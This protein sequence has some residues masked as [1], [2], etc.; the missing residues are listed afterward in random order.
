M[1]YKTLLF[2]GVAFNVAAQYLLRIGM[3]ELGPIE[4]GRRLTEMLKAM[5]INRYFILAVVSYGIGF[6]LYSIVLSRIELS[7]AYPIASVTAIIMISVVSVLFL[8]EDLQ[9]SKIVGVSLCVVG[10]YLIFR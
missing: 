8:K 9:L 7:R 3:R 1:L 6:L 5:F 2:V 10:I 4:M